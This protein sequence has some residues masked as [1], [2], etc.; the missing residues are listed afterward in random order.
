MIPCMRCGLE[1]KNTYTLSLAIF[2]QESRKQISDTKIFCKK[3]SDL[4]YTLFCEKFYQ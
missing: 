1:S 3:C 4:I 2:N